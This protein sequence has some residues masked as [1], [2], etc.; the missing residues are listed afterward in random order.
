MKLFD[1]SDISVYIHIPFFIKKRRGDNAL[2][3]PSTRETRNAYLEALERELMAAGDILEGR[4]IAS[5]SVGGGVATSVS[6]DRLARLMIR[7][8]RAYNVAPRAEFGVAAAPQTMV[9]ACLSSLNTCNINRVSLAAYSPVD[10][11]LESLDTPH[12]PV[13]LETAT[14]ILVKFGFR[15]VDAVLMYGIPGQTLTTIRNTMIAF[16][17]VKGMQHI[18]LKRYELAEESGVSRAECDAQYARA[19][20]TLAERGVMQYAAGSFAVKGNESAFVLHELWGMERA[21]FGLGARSYL[22]GMIYQNTTNFNGYLENAGDFTKTIEA[23]AELSE[24]DKMKRFLALRL[25]WVEGFSEE[26][27]TDEFGGQPEGEIRGI[28]DGLVHNGFVSVADGVFK[29]T[30]LGLCQS[31]V[32]ISAIFG[33]A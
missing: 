23:G 4:R 10:Q 17:S 6:P 22:D 32:L 19:A 11:L 9:S 5:I 3:V 27:F 28:L 21:G 31:D 7:F 16:T 29:P 24:P 15:D 2:V 12:R 30:P 20:E 25:Q 18:T 33:E 13:D 14:A 26:A 1:P 8:K